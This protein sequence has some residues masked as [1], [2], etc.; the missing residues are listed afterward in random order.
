MET[1]AEEEEEDKLLYVIVGK[2]VAINELSI[3]L[4]I[5]NLISLIFVARPLSS[6]LLAH[7]RGGAPTARE[8]YYSFTKNPSISSIFFRRTLPDFEV[9][10]TQFAAALA[11]AVHFSGDAGDR[12]RDVTFH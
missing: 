6:I 10:L 11:L 9:E 2:S 5:K 12:Q 1:G 3:D 7:N 4:L 8:I